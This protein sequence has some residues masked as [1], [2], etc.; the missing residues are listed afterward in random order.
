MRPAFQVCA[1]RKERKNIN[2][3]K[4]HVW[5]T[6]VYLPKAGERKHSLDSRARTEKEKTKQNDKRIDRV[7]RQQLSHRDVSIS[8]LVIMQRSKRKSW[9][10]I[11]KEFCHGIWVNFFDRE[12]NYLSIEGHLKT[13]LCHDRKTPKRYLYTIKEQGWLRMERINKDYKRRTS[14]K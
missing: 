14:R 7:F 8:L 1:W 11:L 13:V 3:C 2:I 9:E 4:V 10:M 5:C 12:P 6:A